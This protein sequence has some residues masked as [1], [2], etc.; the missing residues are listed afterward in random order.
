MLDKHNHI[1]VLQLKA[2]VTQGNTQYPYLI[3]QIPSEEETSVTL[4]FGEDA[5]IKNKF[6]NLEKNNILEGK[7][8]DVIAQ[9]FN[10]LIGVGVIIPSQNFTFNTGP[11]IKCSYK[12]NEGVMYPLEKSILFV[13]VITSVLSVMCHYWVPTLSGGFAVILCAVAAAVLGAVLFPR[14]EEEE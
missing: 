2:Y 4:N 1:F 10:G 8:L 3:F 13:V 11:Y 12:V 9:L 7:F 6:E 14:K 5:E